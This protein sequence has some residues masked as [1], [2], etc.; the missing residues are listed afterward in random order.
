MEPQV[1]NGDVAL[2]LELVGPLS[3]VLVLDILPFWSNAL[4]EKMVIGL[5]SK[6]GGGGNVVLEGVST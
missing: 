2:L 1:I 3:S 6:F 5:K 4:L